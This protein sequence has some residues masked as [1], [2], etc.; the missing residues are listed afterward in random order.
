MELLRREN[1]ALEEFFTRQHPTEP[2]F[3]KNLENVQGDERDV[4]LISIGYGRN[5]SG[6]VAK[7]FGPVNRDGGE[8]RLNVLITRAKLGMEV[9]SNFRADELELDASAR[10]GVRALK[11]FLKYA[12]TG[13]LDIPRETGR[14]ADSPFELEVM[15][16]LR[17][18][19]YQL[20]P[21]VG[22]AGY[23]IDIGVKDPEYPGRYVLAI[24]CDGASYHSARSARDRDRLRQGV[25]ESLGWRFHRIW[26]TD[27]FRNPGKETE[28][29]VA[30]IE[31]AR[32]ATEIRQPI[33]VSTSEV[34]QP[35]IA[36]TTQ[37]NPKAA[38]Q[39]EPYR[40][41]RLPNLCA[42]NQA[43]HTVDPKRLAHEIKAVV[44]VEA[45]V[46]E[47]D[48][49]RRLMESYGLSRAGN[50]IAANVSEAIKAGT[51][52]GLFFYADGFIYADKQREA[53]IRSREALETTERKI[54]LVAPEEIDAALLEVV[55]LGFSMES[56]AAISGALEMLGFGRV[57]SRMKELVSARIDKLLATNRLI[58]VDAML[59]KGQ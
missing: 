56:E 12:E 11:H 36:R 54:E 33:A 2:F 24:E 30:A 3:I 51:R 52:A 5:E 47:V 6:R 15:L 29:A 50:R 48:V 9:F 26:S 38:Y 44:D 42:S 46:H 7:E 41:A 55:R 16:A 57:T 59:R 13:E 18:R 17:E 19:G 43:L 58:Q 22:T 23:F 8:R 10:H 1:P 37:E 31:A 32:N 27:W 35:A 4:I 53:R 25:L 14:T 21:Q 28:R 45:P 39:I 34:A 49:T 40:K 20:E